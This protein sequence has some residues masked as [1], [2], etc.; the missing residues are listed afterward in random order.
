MAAGGRCPDIINRTF[1]DESITLSAGILLKIMMQRGF[2]LVVATLLLA[3]PTAFVKPAGAIPMPEAEVRMIVEASYKAVQD[4]LEALQAA[5]ASG[6]V[7]Q[8]QQA[9]QALNLSIKNYTV[10][11][12]ILSRMQTDEMLNDSTITTSYLIADKLTLFSAQLLASQHENA[13]FSFAEA[14]QMEAFLPNPSLPSIFSSGLAGLQSQ[15]MTVS[16]E[17][18]SLLRSAGIY[19]GEDK[20]ESGEGKL[21]INTH[22]ASPI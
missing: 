3:G 11:S 1:M 19:A 10:A 7:K 18:V 17:S 22:P 6:D 21:G 4:T 13:W 14:K 2:I 8:I 9:L 12:E 5:N 20:T 15:I 16:T